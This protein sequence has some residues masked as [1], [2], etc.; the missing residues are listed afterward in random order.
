MDAV[1]FRGR[2]LDELD[3]ADPERHII[4]ATATALAFPRSQNDSGH[5]TFPKH[6]TQRTSRSINSR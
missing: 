4:K 3:R 5:A 6:S 2:T 1:G